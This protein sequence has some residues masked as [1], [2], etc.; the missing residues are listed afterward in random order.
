MTHLYK[1]RKAMEFIYDNQQKS[2]IPADIMHPSSRTLFRFWEAARGEMAAA[3]KQDL[4]LK[5]VAKIL[6][7]LSILERDAATQIYQWRL[8]GT[9]ICRLWGQEL[10]GNDVLSGWPDFERQ[11]MLSGFDMIVASLQPCVA[12]FKAISSL[13]TEI[14]IE[15]IGFPIQDTNSGAIQ[16]LAAVVPFQTPD[17]LGTQTLVNFEISSMRK[18]WTE[19]LPDDQLGTSR[20]SEF[21][22]QAKT[23]PFLKII[24]GGRP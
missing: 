5:K 18:I 6:P 8:A 11:T 14:G 2:K 15:F 9:G 4:D 19:S 24:D 16:I 1:K 20:T 13:G 12:R 23:P 17:W 3:K 7:N 22:R 10:T 21:T